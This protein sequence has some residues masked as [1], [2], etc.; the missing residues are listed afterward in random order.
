MD[1]THAS[2]V[3]VL[4]WFLVITAILGVG[5][6]GLTKAIIVRSVSLD[7]YLI[8]VSLLF[9][10]GQSIAVLVEAGHGYGSPSDPLSRSQVRANLKSEYAASLL[11]VASL[12]FAKASVLALVK[13]LTPC[14]SHRRALYGLS[15]FVVLW[16]VI[17]EFGTAFLC[18]LPRPWDYLE[19]HCS[20]GTIRHTWWNYIE[21][22][23]I[24]TDSALISLPLVVIWQTRIPSSRKASV[25]SFFA[26]RSTVIAASI[27]KL[28]FWNNAKD[29][30]K[31]GH[32]PWAVLLCTQVVQCFSIISACFLYLK[33]FLDS[34]ESGFIRSDDIRRRG[35]DDFYGHT[36]GDSSTTRSAFSIRKHARNGSQSVGLV[37]VPCPQHT[38]TVTVNDPPNLDAESQT[39]RSHIIKETRTFAVEGSTNEQ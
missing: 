12:C 18:H 3:R 19:G 5:A 17:G 33:P 24:I 11:Y 29:L 7:D 16:A 20:D 14:R 10:I 25:C 32:S 35:T 8:T 27:C 1:D 6:R 26:F 31:L 36:T 4:T 34:V 38:T 22:T 37:G 15:T 23:N 30:Q 21:I 2:T 39:S 13:T 9:A 28:V